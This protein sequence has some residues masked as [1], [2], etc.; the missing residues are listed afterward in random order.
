MKQ[1]TPPVKRFT[2]VKDLLMTIVR[3]PSSDLIKGKSPEYVT[4]AESLVLSGL[5]GIDIV[6]IQAFIPLGLIHPAIIV[7]LF[8][9]AIAIPFLAISIF[10][11]QF[12]WGAGYQPRSF[13]QYNLLKVIGAFFTLIGLNAT[14]WYASWIIGVIFLISGVIG[15]IIALLTIIHLFDEVNKEGKNGE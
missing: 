1:R 10:L 14:F 12:I 7:S 6:I 2:L 13:V 4:T 11:N 8:T 9:F 5:T 3:S 15:S